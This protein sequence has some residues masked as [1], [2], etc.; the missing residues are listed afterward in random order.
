MR[1]S[2]AVVQSLLRCELPDVNDV[3][4]RGNDVGGPMND[5][6]GLP[7]LSPLPWQEGVSIESVSQSRRVPLLFTVCCWHQLLSVGRQQ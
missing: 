4:V 6:G 3:G 7:S 2:S 5:I 1:V